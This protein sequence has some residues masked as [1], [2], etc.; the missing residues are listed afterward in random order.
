MALWAG[1]IK[2]GLIKDSLIK[3][4]KDVS[5]QLPTTFMPPY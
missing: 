3:D 1:R 5:H 2:D 4:S